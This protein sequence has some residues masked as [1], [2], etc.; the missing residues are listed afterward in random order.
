M[1]VEHRAT[2][3]DDF[4]ASLFD[5]FYLG[6]AFEQPEGFFSMRPWRRGAFGITTT[7]TSTTTAWD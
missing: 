3:V 7:S 5:P 2:F 4:R 1:E 6:C